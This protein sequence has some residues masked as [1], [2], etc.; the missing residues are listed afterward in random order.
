M[1]TPT[2]L[3]E[4]TTSKIEG[5]K[6]VIRFSG[7]SGDGM[8]LTGMQFTDTA[9]L[10]GNDLN[11][12]RPREFGIDLGY[13]RRLTEQL[14]VGVGLKYIYSNLAGGTGG[15]RSRWAGQRPFAPTVRF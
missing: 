11:T 2:K 12:F 1:E 14:G 10:L 15:S 6:I 5:D 13:S 9:A 3:L 4:K 7:D 8:Q